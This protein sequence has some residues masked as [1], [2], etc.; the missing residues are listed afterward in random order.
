LKLEY[1]EKD[2]IWGNTPHRP[3]LVAE[4]AQGKRGKLLVTIY[5]T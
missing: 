2:E 3:D 5:R 1:L 4:L